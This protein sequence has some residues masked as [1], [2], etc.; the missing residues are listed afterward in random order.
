MRPYKKWPKQKFPPHE[1]EKMA[2]RQIF[3]QG[4]CGLLA[5]LNGVSLVPISQG[6]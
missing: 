6:M 4:Q 5:L 3:Q 2:P 1:I